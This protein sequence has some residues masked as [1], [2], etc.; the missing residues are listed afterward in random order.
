MRFSMVWAVSAVLLL[1]SCVTGNGVPLASLQQRILDVPVIDD[2]FV[3]APMRIGVYIA[4]QAAKAHAVGDWRNT[5]NGNLLS[6]GV[7]GPGL[8]SGITEYFSKAFAEVYFLS[9]FPHV[10][11]DAADLDAVVVIESGLGSG[12]THDTGMMEP[13]TDV[14]LNVG[15]YTPTGE[16]LLTYPVIASTKTQVEFDLNIVRAQQ[17]AHDAVPETVRRAVR[18]ALAKFPAEQAYTAAMTDRLKRTGALAD[19]ALLRQRAQQMNSLIDASAPRLT[20]TPRDGMEWAAGMARTTNALAVVGGVLSAGL[21]AVPAASGLATVNSGLLSA[22]S[23]ANTPGSQSGAGSSVLIAFLGG[24]VS[25]QLQRASAMVGQPSLMRSGAP[26]A[27]CQQ[28]RQ[29][30]A[31]CTADQCRSLFRQATQN[32]SCG[33]QRPA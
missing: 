33:V 20:A 9:D 23:S 5:P 27:V 2:S 3:A 12:H 19:E 24:A 25:A 17:K 8:F 10:V 30:E 32:L 29:V 28:L 15:V 4:P 16:R 14:L 26:E 1:S 18:L 11:V 13:I 22:I 7:L 6:Y 21:T 31:A